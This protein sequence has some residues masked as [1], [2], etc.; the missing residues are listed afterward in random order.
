M[1]GI[2]IWCMHFIGN[3]A[4]TLKHSGR[5][6][7]IAYAANCTAASFFLPIAVLMSAFYLLGAVERASLVYIAIS[8]TLGGAAIVGM[9]YLGQLGI[10]NYYCHYSL[11]FVIGA[12]I[13]A[14]CATNVALFV[15]FKMR[16]NWSNN[17]WKRLLCACILAGAVS[18]MH[19]VATIGTTYRFRSDYDSSM[20]GLSRAQ[21][22]IVCT[23]LVSHTHL[24]FLNPETSLTFC[25]AAYLAVYFSHLRF[26][27]NVRSEN[28]DSGL[29]SW[30]WPVP[31]LMMPVVSWSQQMANFPPPRSLTLMKR[32]LS[33]RTA[34]VE[35]TQLSSGYSVPPVIGE[36][37]ETSF[38]A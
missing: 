22:V 15:F 5:Y 23:L 14:V 6:G 17:W 32:E 11:G 16:A 9:H 35:H 8:G 1:G 38:L 27:P 4:V 30:C 18:G 25:R 36:L 7:Q 26:L 24:F 2:G 10:A 29:S 28:R 21:T 3:L 31:I 37:S 19:W 12:A 20:V 13:I 34:L 33:T